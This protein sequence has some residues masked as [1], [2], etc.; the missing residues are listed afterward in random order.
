MR[1]FKGWIALDID[2][3]VTLDRY[4]IPKEVVDFLRVKTEEGWRI[5]M[6]TGRPLVFASI[7]VS[8]FD[9]PY[10]FLIQNG[11]LA[12]EMPGKKELFQRYLP[13]ST[14]HLIESCLENGNMLVYSGYG[15][16]DSVYYQPKRISRDLSEYW[17]R[18]R[19]TPAPV[20]SFAEIRQP[21]VP[22]VKCF[23]RSEEMR[24]AAKRLEKHP[25]FNVAFLR[26]PFVED[27][28]LLLITDRQAS[29]GQSLRAAIEQLG[30]MGPII[31]AGDDENDASLL[32]IADVAIAM[33]HAPPSLKSLANLI[34]PPTKDLGILYALR[35]ALEGR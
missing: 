17:E 11:S 18:Q 3:T 7:A 30:E 21:S 25:E 23:G 2:G 8:E 31:A 16:G 9:F 4:T 35:I 27:A 28:C 34:A 29:K 6:A 24:R 10:L 13:T 5:A 19:E 14:L 26:D 12:L 20:E 1:P 32:E 15:L 33:D 22:L